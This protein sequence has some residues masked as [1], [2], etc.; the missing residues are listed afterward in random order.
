M[1]RP[2]LGSPRRA[3]ARTPAACLAALAVLLAG[4]GDNDDDGTPPVSSRPITERC[5]AAFLQP[6]AGMTLT[7]AEI[8]PAANGEPEHCRVQARFAERTGVNGQTYAIQFNLRLPADPAWNGRFLF[9][10]QGGTDGN[11]GDAKGGVGAGLPNALT[12]GFAVV[13][14]DAG[15]SNQAN[16]DPQ[17]GGTATFGLDPQ[18]RL[19]YGY[20]ALD[21]VTRQSK[22]L[23][24]GFYGKGPDR[25][26]VLGCS[27]GGRHAMMASQRFPQHFDG[28]VAGNPGFN[29]PQAAVAEAFDS[30]QF[31]RA[32]T[33]NDAAGRPLIYTA[34]SPADMQLVAGRVTAQCDALDGATDGIVG[35]YRRCGFAPA[36]LDALSCGT[37]P[38]TASC[39]TP[40]QID[41]IRQVM[42][43][44]RNSAGQQLYSDWPWDPG[45]A[46]GGWRAWKLGNANANNL[47][48]AINLTLGAGALP[49]IFTT[50]PVEA[51]D[52]VRYML[53]YSMDVD[54]PKIFATSGPFTQSAMQFMA[55]NSPDLSAFRARGG[56][57]I[58]YHGIADPVFSFNDT[59][60]WY[61][62][63]VA[64]NGGG[65]GGLT[66]TQS[67]AR[68]IPIPGQNH[69]G[70][71]PTV[72]QWD[73]LATIV[74]WVEQN[75]APD[76][77]VASAN[78][79]TPWP[80]RTRP[81]CSYPQVARYTGTGSIEQA[82]SF[83][84]E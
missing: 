21:Q 16:N 56:K 81:L 79:Q 38:K 5:S 61:D 37:G 22:S 12:R 27:N 13:S 23:I 39:I 17:R 83:R 84:C 46:G 73:P 51:T 3:L 77:V 28:V 2:V 58:V 55:P 59:A 26:Y 20:N 49:Y 60:R 19:D 42:A 32:A 8:V 71:G 24:Q 18:A 63:V 72:D 78:A 66:A 65:A 7:A 41:V 29:L 36:S 68:L 44:A 40:T 74:A 69:C 33:A 62:R 11:L 52:L 35:D 64:A 6:P 25:S 70:G 14:T 9:Q 1:H 75:Q 45:I 30:Q 47:N 4:C 15:H 54:A 67:F 82:T 31:A 80:G 48:N 43:G 10:A 50:P 76:A 53:S 57:M 34:F